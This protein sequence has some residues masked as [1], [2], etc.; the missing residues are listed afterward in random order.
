MNEISIEKYI[1]FDKNARYYIET[2]ENNSISRC[3]VE[4]NH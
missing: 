2:E 3:N 4:L 1:N